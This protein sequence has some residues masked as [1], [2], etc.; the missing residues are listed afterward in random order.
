MHASQRNAKN[1]TDRA[2]TNGSFA[3]ALRAAGKAKAPPKV[4]AAVVKRAHAA[5]QTGK[6]HAE[7]GEWSEAERCFRDATRQM[8]GEPVY[9]LNLARVLHAQRRHDDAAQAA[10]RAYNLDPHSELACA[11]TAKCLMDGKRFRDAARCLE[12][13]PADM[14]R[15]FEYHATLGRAYQNGGQP[16]KA[17]NAF[18]N[19]LALNL[20][21][22]DTHYRMGCCLNDLGLKTEAGQ[23]FR[24]TLELGAGKDELGVRGLLT[25][26]EREACHWEGAAEA[27][28]ALKR[29]LD[30]LPDD[31]AVS[32]TPF[33]NLALSDDPADQY[34]TAAVLARHMAQ[35]AQPFAPRRS[36]WRPIDPSH[37]ID[38]NGPNGPNAGR[39]LRVG[40][41][42]ADFHRHATA[43]LMTEML[44]QHDRERFEITLYSHGKDDGSD[45]RRRL[46]R[47]C[48]H[49]VDLRDR[50][51]RDIAERIHAD[52]CDLLIDLKGWTRDARVG[53][54]AWK[55]APVSA[56]FLG[57]PDAQYG[58]H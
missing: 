29:A 14:P 23:C 54:F 32:S 19:A 51:D 50:S 56:A 18:M 16:R 25:H 40:Y 30:A 6:H 55:P 12:S 44:E 21:H 36:D 57:F 17:V 10:A 9:A 28:V 35:Q 15:E 42:S 4:K 27:Q 53:V 24:T 13:L 41:L 43:I 58:L 5:W 38:P 20:T 1:S 2:N 33:A 26:Y 31:A 7:R 39:R 37:P 45:M 8:P 49:F 34:K 22:A 3:A 11:F 47:A 48:E 52:G 46:E